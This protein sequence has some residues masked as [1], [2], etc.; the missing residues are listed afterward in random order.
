MTSTDAKLHEVFTILAYE[1]HKTAKDLGFWKNAEPRN[2]GEIVALMHSELS[3]FLEAMRNPP[4]QADSPGD[5]NLP[6]IGELA[7][8]LIRLFDLIGSGQVCTG[9]DLS[10]TLRKKMEYNTSRSCKRGRAF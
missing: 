4:E 2:I 9:L 5:L 7:D 1:S 6:A 8:L 10:I 3:K